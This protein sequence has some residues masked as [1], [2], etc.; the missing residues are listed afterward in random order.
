MKM[1]NFSSLLTAAVALEIGL[2][3][4]IRAPAIAQSTRS[5]G[6]D[7]YANCRSAASSVV[8]LY[9]GKEIGAGSIINPDGLLITNYHVVREAVQTKG[10]TKIFVKLA[11]GSRYTGQ[12]IASDVKNDLALVQ[13]K[14]GEPLTPIR[15]GNANGIYPGQPVCAIGS[16]KGQTGVLTQGRFSGFRNNTD[17]RSELR[18]FGGNSGGPLLNQQGEMIGINKSIWLSETGENTGIS[19]AV[20]IRTAQQF[21]EQARPGALNSTIAG[22]P[23]PGSQPPTDQTNRPV[24]PPLTPVAQPAL[25]PYLM[26]S[27]PSPLPIAPESSPQNPAPISVDRQPIRPAIV[28]KNDGRLGVILDAKNLIVRQVEIGSAADLSGLR[29]GDRLIAING[30]S[31]QRLEDVQAFLS[32]RPSTGL[33]TVDRNSQPTTVQ[34]NF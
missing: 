11:N 32:Q 27:A 7:T 24:V 16:P 4:V 30:R 2:P 10:Q 14:T 25:E 21:I 8:T 15:F 3:G 33:F 34:V 1:L 6:T 5:A 29:P 9:A 31:I 26:A 12:A 28:K 17:L 19:F 20:N 23:L 22:Q 13:I 18:L